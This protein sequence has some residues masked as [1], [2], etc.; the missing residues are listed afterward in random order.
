MRS[1]EQSRTRIRSVLVIEDDALVS[2]T[3]AVMLD[4]HYETVLVG[5]VE[6]AL[7]HL[8]PLPRSGSEYLDKPAL[9]LLDC[10]LPGGRPTVDPRGADKRRS[11]TRQPDRWPP[12][13]SAEAVQPGKAAANPQGGIRLTAESAAGVDLPSFRL[14]VSHSWWRVNTTGL[15]FNSW[16]PNASTSIWYPTRRGKP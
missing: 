7:A 9:I 10:L 2:E 12:P 6:G 3:I 13:L 15:R 4:G 14:M 8:G 5:T 1:S 11:G 16:T